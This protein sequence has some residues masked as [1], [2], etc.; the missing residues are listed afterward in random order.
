[1][2]P[3]SILFLFFI[4]VTILLMLA[5]K[6]GKLKAAP[7]I[8]VVALNPSVVSAPIGI[9]GKNFVI[10][11]C[12]LLYLLNSIFSRT[13]WEYCLDVIS[14][15]SRQSYRCFSYNPP[16]AGVAAH[17]RNSI[18]GLPASMAVQGLRAKLSP[19]EL[20]SMIVFGYLSI[21]AFISI[22]IHFK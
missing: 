3:Y 4:T 7:Q 17:Q 6:F 10:L 20:E 11:N 22:V 12:L 8:S 13:F 5:V 18:S 21:V 16:L 2:R 1:M 9:I 14:K 15:F 19:K